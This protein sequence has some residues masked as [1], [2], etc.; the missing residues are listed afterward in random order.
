MEPLAHLTNM[1]HGGF[2]VLFCANVI[3]D[4]A[5]CTSSFSHVCVEAGDLHCAYELFSCAFCNPVLW[6]NL[7]QARFVIL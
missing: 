4:C 2:K 5:S 7:C 1:E 3:H 6:A